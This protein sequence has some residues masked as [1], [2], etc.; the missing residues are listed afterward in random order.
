MLPNIFPIFNC[1]DFSLREIDP[2]RDASRYFSYINHGK[3][4]CFFGKN[5]IPHSP[6]S[7]IVELSYWKNLYTTRYS[8]FWAIADN[9]NEII[10]TIGFN[11]LSSI[12]K[13]GEISYDLDYE[14]WGKGIMSKAGAKVIDYAEK[15]MGIMRIQANVAVDNVQSIKLLERLGFKKEGFMKNYAILEGEYKDYFLYGRV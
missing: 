14:H 3:V 2:I 1:E 6:E 4:R 7:A 9:N 12:H 8:I 11:A 5:D 13:R 10:G 15:E